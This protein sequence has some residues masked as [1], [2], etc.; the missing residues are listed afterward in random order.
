MPRAGGRR[1]KDYRFA[2]EEVWAPPAE[3]KHLQ[4]RVQKVHRRRPGAL[5]L[6]MMCNMH[7]RSGF[8]RAGNLEQVNKLHI[9]T[10]VVNKS[11]LKGGQ[12]ISEACTLAE[13]MDFLKEGR[14]AQAMDV[15]AGRMMSLEVATQPGKD[16]KAGA[17]WECKASNYATLAGQ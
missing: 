8:G 15:A 16:H 9:G 11:P 4:Q 5:A 7:E 12:D 13:I 3:A 14:H 1:A 10:Y 2:P 6:Y 17:E